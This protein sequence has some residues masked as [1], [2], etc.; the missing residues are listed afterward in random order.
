MAF[1]RRIEEEVIL[2]ETKVWECTSGSCKC[3]V[4]DNFKS[5][6]TPLCP[7]CKSEMRPTT[8]ELQV[9]PNHSKNFM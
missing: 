4:R 7:I 2:E 6:E 9:I 3:W 8:R 1:G 5:S